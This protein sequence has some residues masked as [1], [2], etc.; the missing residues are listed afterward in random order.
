MTNIRNYT[1]KEILDRVKSVGGKITPNK[2]LLVG[3]QST[4]DATNLFDDMFYVF[5]N[6]ELKGSTTGT[7]NP[8]LTALKHFEKYSTKGAI[9]WKTN[10]FYENLYQRGYHKGRMKALRQVEPIYFYRDNDKD[11]KC[12]EKGELY[13]ENRNCNQHGVDYDPFSN[14][15]GSKIGGWSA[16][17]QVMNN[18]S[19]YRYW[20]EAAWNLNKK[21]DYC[22][23]KE[24]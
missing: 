9:V 13:F 3:I 17:C 5:Y 7:T 6:G 18:M 4:E 10:M 16:G 14:K 15:I 22:L 23:L 21:V 20:I 2:F 1:E 19:L 24:W 8:G 11:G 12:E